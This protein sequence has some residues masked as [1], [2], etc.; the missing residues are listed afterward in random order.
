MTMEMGPGFVFL[1]SSDANSV[2]GQILHM[3]SK[4]GLGL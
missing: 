4:C 3:N 2:T 1:A